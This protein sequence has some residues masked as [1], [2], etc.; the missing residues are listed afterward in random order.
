MGDQVRNRNCWQTDRQTRIN[1]PPR[2]RYAPYK[3][4][5]IESLGRVQKRATKTIPE[6]K[7]RGTNTAMFIADTILFRIIKDDN[8]TQILQHDLD[9]LVEWS[10]TW[11]LSFHPDKCKVM[12]IGAGNTHDY[13]IRTGE[14]SHTL[15]QAAYEKDRD[16]IFDKELE[17]GPQ[18]A[19]QPFWKW[20]DP[21]LEAGIAYIFT[22][23]MYTF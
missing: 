6:R 2:P 11:L 15:L 22:C 5:Y 1:S 4:K 17:W 16:V 23:K 19:R 18:K 13:M 10:E 21:D 7:G 20:V 12:Q 9:Q 8:D 14:T 3:V